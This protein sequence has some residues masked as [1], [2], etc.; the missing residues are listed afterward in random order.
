MLLESQFRKNLTAA[1][2]VVGSLSGRVDNR[3]G[4]LLA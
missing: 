2:T 1:I 3:E 4:A